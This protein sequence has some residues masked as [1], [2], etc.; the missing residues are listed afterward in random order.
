MA[1]RRLCEYCRWMWNQSVNKNI[2]NRLFILI[3]SLSIYRTHWMTNKKKFWDRFMDSVWVDCRLFRW[4]K[5][6]RAPA[7]R[8]SSWICYYNWFLAKKCDAS[9]AFWCARIAMRLLTFWHW[10]WW[11]FVAKYH[12]LVSH[13]LIHSFSYRKVQLFFMSIVTEK[14]NRIKMVRF[15]KVDSMD[16][17]VQCISLNNLVKRMPSPE[18]LSPQSQMLTA[19]VKFPSFI[20]CSQPSS[21]I[22]HLLT[23]HRK[24]V[25]WN[26]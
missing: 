3:L 14:K 17:D 22:G 11:K 16:P 19:E 12:Q 26:D 13:S 21:N 10:N 2:V 15:G 5:G 18:L 23:I 20:Y 1:L 4:F 9:S 7:N 8:V 24:L 25:W 6:H